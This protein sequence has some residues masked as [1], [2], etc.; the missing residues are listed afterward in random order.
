MTALL[1]SVP[2][3]EGQVD[4]ARLLVQAGA[5]TGPGPQGNELLHSECSEATWRSFDCSWR[6]RLT[7][8]LQLRTARQ[9]L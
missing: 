8:I 7:P 3:Q 9:L 6:R 2:F 1:W 4:I 5:G